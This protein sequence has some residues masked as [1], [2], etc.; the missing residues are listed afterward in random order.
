LLGPAFGVFG[1][2]P[3]SLGAGARCSASVRHAERDTKS[4]SKIEPTLDLVTGLWQAK[5]L[6]SP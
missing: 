3:V 2:A 1:L 5:V 4:V 6:R